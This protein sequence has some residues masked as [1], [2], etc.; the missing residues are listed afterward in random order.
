[1]V[2]LFFF[3]RCFAVVWRLTHRCVA[4]IIGHHTIVVTPDNYAAALAPLL[5]NDP[6]LSSVLCVP[7]CP[8]SDA[9]MQLN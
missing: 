9:S 7:E 1:M 6:L 5:S 8:I 3:G 2:F 4:L